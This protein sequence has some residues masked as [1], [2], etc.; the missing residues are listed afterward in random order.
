MKYL[1]TLLSALLLSTWI[2]ACADTSTSK[3]FIPVPHPDRFRLPATAIDTTEL[4]GM[5]LRADDSDDEPLPFYRIA[6]NTYML[7]G[8][9]AQVDE[10]NRGWNGNAG[11]I[12]T[13]EGV[14][15]I[16]SLGTPKLGR[17]FIATIRRVTDQPI[18]YVVLTHNHPDHG[19]GSVAFRRHTTAQLIGHQ[20][21][22]AYIGSQQMQRSVDYRRDI[23]GE[24]MQ[25]F[26]AVI[27]DILVDVERFDKQRIELGSHRFDIYNVGMHHSHGDLLIHQMPEN[28]LWISDLAFNQRTTFMGDGNSRQAIEGLEWL[29]RNFADASLMVPGH[30]SAQRKPFAMVGKT[31]AYIQRLRDEMGQAVDEGIGLLEATKNSDFPDWHDTRLY[32]RN[33]PANAEFIY[34]EMELELF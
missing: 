34:R 12:V 22:L 7:F 11:F 24:D 4:P 6:G 32:Q 8:N 16:D 5:E 26:E 23:L 25:G 21:M 29:V 28:I 13:G 2:T 19:Y 27:P 15:V 1:T 18:R 9:I 33:H 31:R 14:L 20:G 30:G 10:R 3:L 17:R